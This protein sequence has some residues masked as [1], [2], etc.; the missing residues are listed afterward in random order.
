MLVPV[1]RE[2]FP[3]WVT[4]NSLGFQQTQKCEN[5]I[6]AEETICRLGMHGWNEGARAALGKEEPCLWLE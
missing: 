4:F 1:I 3:E 5:V 2:G 6:L